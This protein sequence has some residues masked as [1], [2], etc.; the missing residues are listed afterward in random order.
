MRRG[1][2]SI[3]AVTAQRM[4]ERWGRRTETQPWCRSDGRGARTRYDAG[5]LVGGSVRLAVGAMP[6]P[7]GQRPS[8]G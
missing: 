8:Q 7:S 6:A 3:F 4:V 2:G 5:G 1:E